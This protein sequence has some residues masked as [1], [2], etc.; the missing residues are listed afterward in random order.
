M[1]LKPETVEE[2]LER[3]TREMTA[4][5]KREGIGCEL[6]I[7][8][9]DRDW[10]TSRAP[11]AVMVGGTLHPDHRAELFGWLTLRYLAKTSGTPPTG[12]TPGSRYPQ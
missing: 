1:E 12:S 6:L 4:A 11:D 8:Q 3:H 10:K 9:L 2:M 7:I 5:M